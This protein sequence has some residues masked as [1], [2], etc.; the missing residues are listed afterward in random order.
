MNGG[1]DIGKEVGYGSARYL[2]V[3]EVKKISNVLHTISDGAFT[4]QYDPQELSDCHMYPF[5]DEW[6]TDGLEYLLDCFKDMKKMYADCAKKGN[7]M[8]VYL[9]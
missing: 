8:L 5:N 4:A 9:T 7:A 3:A 1:Q 2:T 6:D